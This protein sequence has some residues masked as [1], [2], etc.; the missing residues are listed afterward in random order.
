[1]RSLT[2]WY[3]QGFIDPVIN[4][5]RTSRLNKENPFGSVYISYLKRL[6]EEFKRIGNRY[7][8]GPYSKLNALRSSLM[9]L[10]N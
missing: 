4:S 8:I 6:S 7:N 9:K 1:M 10:I 3:P 5:E 2:Q